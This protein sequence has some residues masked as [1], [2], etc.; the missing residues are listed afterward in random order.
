M[1]CW[2]N[3]H[4]FFLFNRKVTVHY[5]EELYLDSAMTVSSNGACPALRLMVIN[6]LTYLHWVDKHVLE[7]SERD[8]SSFRYIFI[9][10]WMRIYM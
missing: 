1:K 8:V 4:F 3:T 10:I 5:N 9:S 7:N 6:M 2:Y